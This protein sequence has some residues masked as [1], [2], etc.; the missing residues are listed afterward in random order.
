M[1]DT[2]NARLSSV[3]GKIFKQL[4][5]KTGVYKAVNHI[6]TWLLVMNIMN[7]N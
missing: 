3:S 2:V 5:T 1:D 7:L 6:A 4:S